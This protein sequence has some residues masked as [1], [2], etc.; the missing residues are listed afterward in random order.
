[1][2][3]SRCRPGPSIRWQ[4]HLSPEYSLTSYIREDVTCINLPLTLP[5]ARLHCDDA[6][7]DGD[8]G[9]DHLATASN[10]EGTRA[11]MRSSLRPRAGEPRR[12]YVASIDRDTGSPLA[13]NR[14]RH[15]TVTRT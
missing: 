12:D 14:L 10:I 5:S 4:L 13:F 15:I 6:G 3:S 2:P 9:A 11:E 1:V 7:I 8:R